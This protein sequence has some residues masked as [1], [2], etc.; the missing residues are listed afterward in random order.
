MKAIKENRIY[1]IR[2]RPVNR[3]GPTHRAGAGADGKDTIPR[4]VR[5]RHNRIQGAAVE[6]TGAGTTKIMP[7]DEKAMA[8]ARAG[9][10]L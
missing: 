7:L 8:A 6:S 2:R 1:T 3:S 10:T 5:A 4:A 9:R